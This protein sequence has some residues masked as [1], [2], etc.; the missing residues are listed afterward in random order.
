MNS[1]KNAFIFYINIE[2]LK[3]A[4]IFDQTQNNRLV[5]FLDMKS[6]KRWILCNLYPST[7]TNQIL[8]L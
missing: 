7:D 2:F 5:K 3:V 1:I 4:I 6:Q 8:G